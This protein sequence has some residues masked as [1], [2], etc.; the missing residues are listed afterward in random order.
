M[1]PLVPESCWRNTQ[2][3]Y[4]HTQ[5]FQFGTSYYFRIFIACLLKS[6]LSPVQTKLYIMEYYSW[7]WSKDWGS[8]LWPL[9][10]CIYL[11]W[12][13]NLWLLPISLY[14]GSGL[15]VDGNERGPGLEAKAQIYTHTVCENKEKASL[16][17]LVAKEVS[18]CMAEDGMRLVGLQRCQDKDRLCL[19]DQCVCSAELSPSCWQI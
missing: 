9:S 4:V 15:A 13:H 5:L 14:L 18:A 17:Q 12:G 2:R 16:L 1:K 10:S 11:R 8:V 7:D 3:F 6:I 19:E